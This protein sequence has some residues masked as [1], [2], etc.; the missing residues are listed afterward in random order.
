M[1]ID[2]KLEALLYDWQRRPFVLGTNDC[3]Q[4]A[5]AAAWSLHTVLVEHE[6][7]TTDRQALRVLG[8]LG[9]YRGLLAR[10]H[11]PVPTGAAQRGDIVI[12]PGKAPYR[13]ALGVVTGIHAH[14]TGH[15]G[16]VE[17]PRS[18]WIECWRVM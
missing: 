16:L 9:G 8:A 14:T 1:M 7:Y 18:K 6:P 12:L 4:F 10:T 3:C 13:E 15:Y 5:R 2:Q 11:R 17:V